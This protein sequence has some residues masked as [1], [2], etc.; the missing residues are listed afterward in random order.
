[1]NPKGFATKKSLVTLGPIDDSHPTII[2]QPS[3]FDELNI[4]FDDSE[5]ITIH[6]SNFITKPKGKIFKKKFNK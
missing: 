4:S 3:W 2:K 6:V 1:M 5:D